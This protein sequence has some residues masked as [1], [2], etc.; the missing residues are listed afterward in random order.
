[1]GAVRLPH[2]YL[3]ELGEGRGSHS[4][5][6]RGEAADLLGVDPQSLLETSM[7]DNRWWE[8]ITGNKV[9]FYVPKGARVTTGDFTRP[10][11]MKWYIPDDVVP[12]SDTI[13]H[14]AC[15]ISSH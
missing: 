10:S 7:Y 2:T 14:L 12:P 8:I 5:L 9:A 3:T 11:T 13:L 15:R 4:P 6:T 1:M